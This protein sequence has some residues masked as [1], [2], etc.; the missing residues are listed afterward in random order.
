VSTDQLKY[1][2]LRQSRLEARIRMGENR[3]Y[4]PPGLLGK[5]EEERRWHSALR[6]ARYY[7]QHPEIDGGRLPHFEPWAV[8]SKEGVEDDLATELGA[9]WE[10]GANRRILLP[11]GRRVWV[12]FS[13]PDC[14]SYSLPGAFW[15]DIPRKQVCDGWGFALI[16][17]AHDQTFF[18]PRAILQHYYADSFSTRHDVNVGA[19]DRDLLAGSPSFTLSVRGAKVDI[20]RYWLRYD[21]LE[22]SPFYIEPWFH[23]TGDVPDAEP[24]YCG[25]CG[26]PLTPPPEHLPWAYAVYAGPNVKCL[27]CRDCRRSH[28]WLRLT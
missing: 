3:P 21:L 22:V 27:I 8:S 19:D 17:G 7:L 10:R 23:A 18:I 15:F 2:E 9:S 20:G 25:I 16:C 12:K 13:R 4:P 5:E 24:D 11:N 28:A 14:G 26:Q 6:R 1:R